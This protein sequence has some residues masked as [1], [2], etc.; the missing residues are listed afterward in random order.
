MHLNK[1]IVMISGIY[2]PISFFLYNCEP[3]LV[4]MLGQNE[5]ASSMCQLYLR[6]VIPALYL[7]SIFDSLEMFMIAMEKS[8][9]PCMV[10]C[11]C[12]P[13]HLLWCYLFTIYF[14]MGWFGVALAQNMTS[15]SKVLTIYIILRAQ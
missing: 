5:L 8:Y 11:V 4:R 13:L 15:V 10:Q 12:I 7:D 2:I 3:I 9:I 14:G 1:Q 6:N